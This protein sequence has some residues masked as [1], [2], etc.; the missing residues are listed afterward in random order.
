MSDQMMMRHVDLSSAST[1]ATSLKAKVNSLKLFDTSPCHAFG[2]SFS[3][4]LEKTS[5]SSLIQDPLV[6]LLV[7]ILRN[8]SMAML[9]LVTK[10]GLKH[11]FPLL[12]LGLVAH[13]P[14]KADTFESIDAFLGHFRYFSLVI[15]L[16]RFALSSN[17]GM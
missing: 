4:S 2:L 9:L 1:I 3:M 11:V 10:E 16:F 14:L 8:S 15:V 5:T 17:P 12:I 13:D 7:F 6:E